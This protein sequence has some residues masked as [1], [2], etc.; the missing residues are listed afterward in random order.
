SYYTLR[1]ANALA[2]SHAVS[3]ILMRQLLP[4]C[5]YPGRERVGASLT[6]LK[7]DRAIHL[8][9]G[10]DWFWLPSMF[11]ALALLIREKPDMVVFQWWTGTVLHSY[12]ML[13][14]VARL[15]GARIVVEFHEVLDP[16]EMQLLL[17]RTYVHLVA[18]LLMRLASGF[19]IHSE[20]DRP[21]L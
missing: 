3:V 21:V 4:T 7:Y 14:L 12:L 1:L 13:A 6:Q 16:G 18:P 5:F 15:L 2:G 17:P 11:C 19:V 8:Y 9:N 20:Y 10:V